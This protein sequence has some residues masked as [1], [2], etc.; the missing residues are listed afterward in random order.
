MKTYFIGEK[1]VTNL[2]NQILDYDNYGNEIYLND[3]L[4][5]KNGDEAIVYDINYI[6]QLLAKGKNG[7]RYVID[8]ESVIK[9]NNSIANN[10]S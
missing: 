3:K 1:E 10:R 4:A 5:L 6:G 2:K 8:G 9:I 7:I